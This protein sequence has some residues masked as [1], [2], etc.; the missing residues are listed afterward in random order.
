MAL[1]GME[2]VGEDGTNSVIEFKLRQHEDFWRITE[3]SNLEGILDSF[4]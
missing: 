4:E 3:V 2:F 1:L